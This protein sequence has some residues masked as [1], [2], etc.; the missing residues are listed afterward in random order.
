MKILVIN[1]GGMSTKIAVYDNGFLL[2]KKSITHSKEELELFETIVEQKD[3]RKSLILKA[4]KEEG[5]ELRKIDQFV[6]RGE[7]FAIYIAV[8]IGSMKSM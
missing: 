5:I 1:P 2:F 4:L 6:G 3:F 8:F 7:W